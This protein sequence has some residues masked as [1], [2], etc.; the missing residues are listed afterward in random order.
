MDENE[1]SANQRR[2]PQNVLQKGQILHIEWVRW[3]ESG[4]FCSITFCLITMTNFVNEIKI[5]SITVLCISEVLFF[6]HGIKNRSVMHVLMEVIKSKYT[7]KHYRLGSVNDA[8]KAVA[9]IQNYFGG[10]SNFDKFTR[11][12]RYKFGEFDRKYGSEEEF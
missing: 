10:E 3:L 4:I 8:R 6:L 1:L 12:L 9:E 5:I 2:I 7:R 11:R